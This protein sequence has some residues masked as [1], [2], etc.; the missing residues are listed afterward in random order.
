M[1][2]PS[3]V[4]SLRLV[5]PFQPPQRGTPRPRLPVSEGR[6]AECHRLLCH[7]AAFLQ[8]QKGGGLSGEGEKGPGEKE[9]LG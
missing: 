9:G 8:T 3:K 2:L 6:R 7:E 5:P 1:E 4:Q